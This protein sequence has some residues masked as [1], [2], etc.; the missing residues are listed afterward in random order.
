M[1]SPKQAHNE[2]NL[3]IAFIKRE[4]EKQVEVILDGK[5]LHPCW[6]FCNFQ[7][8]CCDKFWFSIE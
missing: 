1:K 3:N 2:M 8:P 7:I 4:A 5:F 6:R